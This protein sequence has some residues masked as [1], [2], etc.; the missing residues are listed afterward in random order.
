MPGYYGP[1]I[2]IE[3]KAAAGGSSAYTL[4]DHN[5]RKVA[6]RSDLLHVTAATIFVSCYIQDCHVAAAGAGFHLT[7]R[8]ASL[9]TQ[10]SVR[11]P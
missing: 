7:G 9:K 1:S 11:G 10:I 5:G 3:R 8:R 6:H 2:T 4:Y